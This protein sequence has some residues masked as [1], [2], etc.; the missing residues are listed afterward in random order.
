MPAQKY[1]FISS[2]LDHCKLKW[3]F[4][5]RKEN[6]ELLIDDLIIEE[7]EKAIGC[8]GHPKTI[9]ALVKGRT[10]SSIDLNSLQ[11]VECKKEISCGSFLADCLRKIIK[12]QH[13][14]D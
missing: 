3:N 6:N 11:E 8:F 9:T 4:T 5:I 2:D 1:E 7:R 10:I 14:Q 12:D 13:E